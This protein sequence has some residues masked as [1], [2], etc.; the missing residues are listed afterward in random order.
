MQQQQQAEWLNQWSMFTDGERFLLEDW[1]RPAS[2]GD[3]QGKDVLECG[4]GGGHH[5]AA[6][7]EVARTV[8]AVDLNCADLAQGRL[9]H[10]GHVAFVSA[11]LASMDLGRQFD[12]VVCIGVIHH[13]DNPTRTFENLY[14]HCRPGGMVIIWTYSAEGN[15]LVRFLLEPIRKVFLSWMPRKVVS[16][17]SYVITALLYPFVYSIY[18][19]PAA[20]A[21]PYYEY[22]QNFRR[23]SFTRNVLNVFDKLNAPQTHF[24]TRAK[25]DEWFNPQRFDPD[26]I[27]I[28]PYVGVSYSL[29]GVRR[30]DG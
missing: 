29:V 7:A 25:C 2:L 28:T 15:E 10:L 22:F 5:T 9:S 18:R 14:R 30:S 20:R 19:L 23:L 1:I 8:T 26:S 13:T 3:L 21:L 27:R 16:A 24:T 6:F 12:V 4:C 17:M 11:D